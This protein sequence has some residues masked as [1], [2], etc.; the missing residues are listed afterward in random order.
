MKVNLANKIFS[1]ALFALTF[2]PVAPLHA[3]TYEELQRQLQAEQLIN[4]RLRGRVGELENTVERLEA[5]IAGGTNV[6]E[7][8]QRVTLAPPPDETLDESDRGALEEALVQRGSAVLAP[9][10]MQIVPSI[11][12]GHAGS[13]V[14]GTNSDIYQSSL[15]G[16]VG[17]PM[18]WMIDV[19]IPYVFSAENS[20][21]SNSGIGDLSVTITKQLLAPS[22]M[23]P[24]LLASIGYSAPTG[25]GSFETSV[26]T[27]SGFHRLKGGL[28]ATK[29][30]D[31][32]VFYGDVSYAHSFSRSYQGVSVQPGETFGVGVGSTLAATPDI[33]L[34]LGLDFA[35]VGEY[36][37]GGVK[38][39][40]SDS[41]I[42]SL[43]VGAGFILSRT[44]YLSVSGQF[45]VTD[46][47]SDVGVSVA[48][49]IRF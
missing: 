8:E 27:G 41:T 23:R 42:G 12:W 13:S 37:V 29:A 11:A 31:P 2:F 22:D 16:R 19:G 48:L 7:E 18:G 5:Q 14:L 47:A 15:T 40:G 3:Q 6:E 38:I 43:G 34:S 24:S 9:G 49:P 4:Q 10:S 17:L 20:S 35:F 28:S 25:E 45:G 46:D 30:V 33:A 1:A 32:V 26:P 36:E 21:G 44:T 39:M